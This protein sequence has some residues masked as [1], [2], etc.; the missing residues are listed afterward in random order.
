MRLFIGAKHF[1]CKVILHEHKQ[2]LGLKTSFFKAQ[3]V[4][5]LSNQKFGQKSQ[6]IY[7]YTGCFKKNFTTL[8]HY[9]IFRG[10]VQCFKL[11]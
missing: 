1:C 7:E 10:H 3:G 8:K 9:I 4:L 11:S 2:G 5:E 6:T